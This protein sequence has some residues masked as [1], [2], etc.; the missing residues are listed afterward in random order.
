MQ[1]SLALEDWEVEAGYML[2][3]QAQPTTAEIEITY[4]E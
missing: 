4:D 2:C 1:Q 3:C